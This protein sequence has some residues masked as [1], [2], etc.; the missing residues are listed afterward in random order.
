[1]T[2]PLPQRLA[3]RIK[4]E[5]PLR[6]DHFMEAALYDPTH[7][8]YAS[9]QTRTGTQGDFLT[10]VSTGPVLGQL[11]ARQV[12]E[13]HAALRRPSRLLLVEQGA[14]RGFL[15]AD[16]LQ[17]I[18]DHHP[19]LR[20]AVELHLLEPSPSLAA[21][22]KSHL[23]SLPSPPPIS[24]HANPAS[25]PSSDLPLFFY[26]CELVD[27][28]P[29]RLARFT[30][31]GWQELA[32]NFLGGEFAWQAIP[33]SP[34]LLLS[35]ASWS[36]PEILGFTAEVRPTTAPWIRS[37]SQKFCQGMIF[38]MDYGY[39]A[40]DLYH[41]S[42]SSGTLTALRRH[43]RSEQP[44]HHPGEQDLTAH[45]NFSE[46]IQ[47]GERAGLT[48]LGL[49]DFSRGLT[50]LASP[51]LQDGLSFSPSWTRNFQHLTHPN[52]FGRSHQI[53]LQ[54]KGLP[55]SFCPAPLLTSFAQADEPPNV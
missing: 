25:F 53:L 31:E 10:P 30:A 39:L 12:D 4:K 35:L 33:P 52:F 1:M 45:V 38:T 26:S 32:V 21:L 51:L 17:A 54:G 13:L 11:L 36:A 49:V 28:F 15:A 6:F 27:S 29:V 9:G 2:S 8:F 5:G 16:L 23:A 47:E 18:L 42:R 14:D 46:L 43:R 48:S 34:D 20:P 44:L 37:L 50:R 55:S 24:W 7:G 40:K 22:Q 3:A 19:L 41:P